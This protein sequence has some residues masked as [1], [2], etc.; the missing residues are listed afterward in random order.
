MLFLH[1]WFINSTPIGSGKGGNEKQF[2]P[3]L[4]SRFGEGKREG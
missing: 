3:A 1:F 2:Y 4:Y